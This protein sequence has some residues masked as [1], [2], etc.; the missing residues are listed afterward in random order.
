MAGATLMLAAGASHATPVALNFDGVASGSTADSAASGLGIHF[1]LASFLPLLDGSGDPIPGSEA[2]RPDP[3]AIDEA[4]VG[5]PNVRGYGNA[6]SPGNALDA[7][8]Q[9]IVILFDAPVTLASFAVTLDQSAFGFPGAF[10]IVFQGDAGAALQSLPTSQNVPGFTA[11]FAGTL[12]NVASIYLP[13]GAYYDDL[14]FEVVP[15]PATALL[16][17]LGLGGLASIRRKPKS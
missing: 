6:P 11:S 16:M 3:N 7:I 12:A 4:R 15:E 10:D 1:A 5:D 9:G 13:S 2:Y 14:R 17:A 8:D